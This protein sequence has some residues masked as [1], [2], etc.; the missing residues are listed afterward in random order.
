MGREI[1]FKPATFYL[2]IAD[3]LAT[4]AEAQH[5]ESEGNSETDLG[6][7]HERA[8]KMG[9]QGRRTSG[10]ERAVMAESLGAKRPPPE[11]KKKDS[12]YEPETHEPDGG[13]AVSTGVA[14]QKTTGDDDMH[15]RRTGRPEGRRDSDNLLG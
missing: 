5:S 7:A 6:P 14:L 10:E 3:H 15:A 2:G 4:V 9:M 1:K 12:G 13:P 11:M 8:R